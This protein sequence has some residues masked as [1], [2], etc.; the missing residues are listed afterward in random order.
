METDEPEELWDFRFMR[1]TT[2]VV[3]YST[4]ELWTFRTMLLTVDKV[5]LIC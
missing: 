5:L 1:L 3:R 4:F 2:F